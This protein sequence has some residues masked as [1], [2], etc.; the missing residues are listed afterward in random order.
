MQILKLFLTCADNI[1]TE[2]ISHTLFAKRLIACANKMSVSSIFY[3]NGSIE[4]HN[5]VLLIMETADTNFSEIEA[6]IK[7]LSRIKKLELI[8]K[9]KKTLAKS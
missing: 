3:W 9:L 1:E 2:K 8:K 5:E 4:N 7:K 6:E